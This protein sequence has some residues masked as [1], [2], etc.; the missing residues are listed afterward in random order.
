MLE[1]ALAIVTDP[2]YK[3]DLSVQLG[4]LEVAKVV[5]RSNLYGLFLISRHGF[6]V[7]QLMSEL[8]IQDIAEEAQSESKWK[9]LGE[10]AM[11]SGKVR[12]IQ[13]V[14]ALE[15]MY[16]AICIVLLTHDLE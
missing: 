15:R 1:E 7:S 12:L 3:F 14:L 5:P 10:L 2:D 6:S 4:R 9:Q 11:S 8:I 16:S 13:N